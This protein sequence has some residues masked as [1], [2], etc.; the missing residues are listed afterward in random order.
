MKVLALASYPKEAAA[1]R[2]RLE[3]FV[4]PLAERGICLTIRPFI[5]SDLFEQLYRRKSWPRTAIGLMKSALL[6]SSDVL[7]ARQ[8]EV[9][10]IQ[11][12]AMIF[13]PPVIEFYFQLS[14]EPCYPRGS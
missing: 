14:S 10:L 8:T 3:Q 2:Y 11:R 1:T 12:E 9:V 5:D 4:A 7:V 13:G 6:R